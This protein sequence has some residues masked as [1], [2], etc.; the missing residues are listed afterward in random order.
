MA[1]NIGTK[2]IRTAYHHTKEARAKMSVSHSGRKLPQETKS[3]MRTCTLNESAFGEIT[4][5]SVYWIGFLMA[6]GNI[7][8]KK[9]IPIIALHLKDIDI[10]HLEKFRE[11]VGSSHKV[12]CYVNKTWGNTS[13]SISFSSERIANDL[14]K[15]GV[16][17]KKCFIAK[18]EG[19]IEYDRNLWRGIIDGDGTLD[20]YVRKNSNGT[21]RKIPYI[22]LTGSSNICLQF[23]TFLEKE[24]Q[25][26]MP[27]VI[28]NKNSYLF[29]VSDHR[30][31]KIIKLLYEHCTIALDRK[32]STAHN[33]MESFQIT[34]NTRFIKRL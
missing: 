31:I 4:E 8:Y 30:A 20:I 9:E 3:K 19:G 2:I 13:Y 11:F 10:Q 28:S 15:Y 5:Q 23:K 29:H 32:L 21:T 16:L 7:C 14:A 25:Q 6:D 12:G 24:L 27:A 1:S 33:L 34:D 18:I 26:S 22:S 17:P